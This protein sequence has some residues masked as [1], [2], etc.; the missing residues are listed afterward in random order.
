MFLS[1]SSLYST[2][3]TT[4]SIRPSNQSFRCFQSVCHLREILCK[5]RSYNFC[6]CLTV[7][8]FSVLCILISIEGPSPDNV[9]CKNSWLIYLLTT[10]RLHWGLQ[11]M[12]TFCRAC[13][14]NTS[15]KRKHIGT[16]NPPMDL[17]TFIMVV[18]T[19][20][21]WLIFDHAMKTR[22]YE[23]VCK[24]CGR[25]DTTIGW[26]LCALSPPIRA[27]KLDTHRR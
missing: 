15:H 17:L 6:L 5:K 2:R 19:C 10:G 4:S 11:G 22:H 27:R 16:D 9:L 3:I 1:L 25:R 23:T 7:T 13:K 8:L 26:R 18:G 20:G 21:L 14:K 12:Y 24:N